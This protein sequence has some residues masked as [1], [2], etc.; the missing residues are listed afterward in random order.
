LLILQAFITQLA[1]TLL[2]VLVIILVQLGQQYLHDP[3]P[4][5]V[6]MDEKGLQVAQPP[7]LSATPTETLPTITAVRVA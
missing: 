6:V 3:I 1:L 4:G 2:V 7:L 5:F